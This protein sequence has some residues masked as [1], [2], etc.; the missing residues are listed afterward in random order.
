MNRRKWLVLFGCVAFSAAAVL[1]QSVISAQSGLIHY[2]QGRVFL[3]NDP[4]SPKAGQFPQVKEGQQ[5]RTEAGRAEVLLSPGVFLRVAEDS[6]FRMI[7]T[8]LSASR[9]EFLSGSIL[10]EAAEVDKANAITV[11]FREVTI[12]QAKDGLYRLDAEP[13]QLRVFKGEVIV[14]VAGQ[15]IEVDKGKFLPLDGTLAV[16]KFDRDQADAFDRWSGR[17]AEHLALANVY[18][19]RSLN[20]SGY[21]L[22]SSGWYWNPYFGMYTFVPLSGTYLS[23]Y[24]YYFW[25]PSRVYALYAPP[26]QA[27]SVSYG[28]GRYDANRG[29]TVMAPT[30][31]G[32][33]GN[34]ARGA[35]APTTSSSSSS[36]PISRDTGQGGGRTR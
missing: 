24:G 21:S 22:R 1:A 16:Q 3:G 32:N 36:A 13:A 17:R 27:P 35:S 23:P 15:R 33:S 18:A 25:S 20:R 7:D 19:A 31:T 9:L 34:M 14:D 8:R 28:G 30:V 5:L 12:S 10:V 2:F 4:V 29:Y 11:V 6:S 26:R